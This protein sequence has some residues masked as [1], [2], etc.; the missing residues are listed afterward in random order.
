[1]PEVDK[2]SG[3]E[4]VGGNDSVFTPLTGEVAVEA[5]PGKDQPGALDMMVYHARSAHTRE[6][7][8]KECK[9]YL[10]NRD[11]RFLTWKNAKEMSDLNQLI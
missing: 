8:G 1:M 2:G 6:E 9:R 11:F 4:K 7:D 3:V 5:S 10:K